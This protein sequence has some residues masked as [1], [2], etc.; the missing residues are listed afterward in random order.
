MQFIAQPIQVFFFGGDCGPSGSKNFGPP[1]WL[2][3]PIFDQSLSPQ[4]S[5]VPGN[6]KKFTSFFSHFWLLFSSKLQQKALF[7]AWNTKICSNF[8]VG[9][10]FWPQRTI[11]PSFP[12]LTQ[13]S[14][15]V[16][17]PHLTPSLM[18][19]ENHPRKQVSPHQKFCKKPCTKPLF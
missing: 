1:H 6:F 10:H 13:S 11:F 14:T 5:F 18:G 2:L 12:H 17:P 3:S 7:Y 8:A 4:L 16:L 9:G 19:T 15:R